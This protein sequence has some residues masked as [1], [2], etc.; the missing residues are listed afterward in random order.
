MKTEKWLFWLSLFLAAFSLIN[1]PWELLPN[2]W[3][4]IF[5]S[6]LFFLFSIKI[7]GPKKPWGLLIF[8]SLVLCD[9]IL[10]KWELTSAKFAYYGLH[11]FVILSLVLL[12]IRGMEWQKISWFEIWSVTLFLI[13]SSIVFIALR[14][15]FTIENLLLKILF[16]INGFLI[17][18]LV[19]LSFFNS[20]NDSKLLGSSF[21]LGILG[22]IFSELIMFMIYFL[23]GNHFRYIDNFFYVFGLFFL[24]K[25]SLENKLMKQSKRDRQEKE[26]KKEITSSEKKVYR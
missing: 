11:S 20:I 16:N 24:L 1:I 17:V 12:T 19:V 3:L 23:D 18:L 15:Y 5:T 7:V 25:V 9:F 21:F 2:R 4:R 22:I 6:T 13:F 14:E 26:E 10:L 8:A